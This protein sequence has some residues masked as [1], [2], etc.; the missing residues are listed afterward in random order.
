MAIEPVY[1][2]INIKKKSGVVSG[3]IKTETKTDVSSDTVRKVLGI[4]AFATVMED[5]VSDG[6]LKYG[7]KIIYH[8][9]Y[10]DTDGMLKK[11]ECGSEFAGVLLSEEIKGCCEV[12]TSVSVEKTEADVGGTRLAIT[13]YLNIK[14][15]LSECEDISVLSGG[16][17]LILD[18]KELSVVRGYGLKRSAYPVEEEFELNYPVAE[19]LS[20]KIRTVVTA[21][22]CGVG[23]IIVDGE[24][25][26]TSLLLQS[27]DK[28]DIIREDRTLPF[29]MEIECEEAMPTMIATASVKEKSF[30]TDIAVDGDSGKSI[31]T[32]SVTLQFE[33]EAFSTE[34]VTVANDAFN[35][36]EEIETCFGECAFEKPCDPRN[37]IEKISGRAQTEELPVGARFIA[38]DNEKAEIVSTSFTE[39]GIKV[40]GV[41][42]ATA[43]LRDEGEDFSLRLETPFETTL[44]CITGDCVESEIKAVPLRASV[45]MVS[46]TE[47]E[48]D[49]DVNFT[50]CQTEKQS[51]KYIKDVKSCGDKKVCES[52]ISVY[53]PTEGEDLWSLSKRLNVCPEALIATNKE[54]QFPLSGKERIVIY[55][56]K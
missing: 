5:D 20:Q 13:A 54:L 49:A 53:I 3:Q 52:A 11:C 44:A 12:S 40:T 45:R 48:L 21:V 55:R 31:V 8:I 43:Y 15:E 17:N 10:T 42:S 35:T 22:Q 47:S 4:T 38:V 16:E 23:C 25:Y 34:H 9:T 51:F 18:S 28:R 14:A 56:Q 19:V 33:G 2:K 27:S 24:V 32:I 37:F 39:N 1:E 46:L 36:G 29:R 30:K 6:Q 50:I 41:L 7:G 26:L